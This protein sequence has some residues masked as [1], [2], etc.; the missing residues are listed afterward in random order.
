LCVLVWFWLVSSKLGW[1]WSPAGGGQGLRAKIPCGVDM[2]GR[3][4]VEAKIFFFL[5][6]VDKANFRLE[7][8]RKDF[9]GFVFVGVQ[10]LCLA[11]GYG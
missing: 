10:W 4:S 2:E 9:V 3:F 6:R 8:R 11:G 7:E 1:C 5:V